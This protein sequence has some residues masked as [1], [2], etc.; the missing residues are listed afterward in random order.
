MTIKEAVKVF[1][2][3]YFGTTKRSAKTLSAYSFDLAQFRDFL[4]CDT[5]LESV[6]PESLEAWAA[7]CNCVRT[8]PH[9]FD[10]SLRPPGCFLAIGFAVT[11]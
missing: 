11:L 5:S 8:P 2:A 10:G 9:Q 6:K 4:G 1:L 3:G 7:I